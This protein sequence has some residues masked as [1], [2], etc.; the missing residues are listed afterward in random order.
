MAP[1]GVRQKQTIIRC[2]PGNI[3]I[4]SQDIG[5]PCSQNIHA[6]LDLPY[7]AG[8][9]NSI[10]KKIKTMPDIDIAIIPCRIIYT[11]IN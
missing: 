9:N 4:R 7:P 11:I 8:C 1:C 3:S 2:T 6:Q 10:M 5:S